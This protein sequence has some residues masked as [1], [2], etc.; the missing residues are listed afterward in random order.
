MSDQI[1]NLKMLLAVGELVVREKR[2]VGFGDYDC[3][4]YACLL[5]YYQ[6]R[7]AAFT[8]K[9]CTYWS[10]QVHEHF[11]LSEQQAEVLFGESNIER[12]LP[13]FKRDGNEPGPIADEELQQRLTFLRQLISD[14]E[15]RASN[16]VSMRQS[17]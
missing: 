5:G 10:P 17:A 3:G 2:P 9:A 4:T 1:A 13:L 11:G 16:V 15:A 12:G 14:R 8:G 6:R 7:T